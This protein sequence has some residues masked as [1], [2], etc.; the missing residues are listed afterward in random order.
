MIEAKQIEQIKNAL[1]KKAIGCKETE[2]TFE[3]IIDE[4]TN[5]Q[6]ETKRKSREIFIAPDTTACIKLL[7]IYEKEKEEE[8]K[9]REEEER[10]IINKLT[11]EELQQLKDYLDEAIKNKE[12]K[13]SSEN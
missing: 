9:K 6:H 1:Y 2:T 12:H 4:E 7:D 13:T 8:E 5:T 10:D 11:W 3:Y